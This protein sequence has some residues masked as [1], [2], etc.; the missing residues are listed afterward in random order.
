MKS[1]ILKG[2]HIGNNVVIGANSL[3][4]KDVSDDCVVAGNL[5]KVIMSLDEYYKK[6]NNMKNP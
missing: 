1:R 6:I 2:V 4:N 3:V 5:A